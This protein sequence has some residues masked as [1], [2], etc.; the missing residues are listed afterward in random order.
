MGR[1]ETLAE[2]VGRMM[3]KGY[4]F[5]RH[6]LPHDARQTERTG[7]TLEQELIRAGLPSRSVVVVPKTSS[8]WIGINHAQEMFNVLS[9]RSPQCD[10]GVEA[11]GAYRQHIEAEGGVTRGEPIGDWA[12][13]PADAFRTMAEAHRAGLIEFRG[14][15]A[16]AQGPGWVFNGF[17]PKRRGM[18]PQRV[19]AGW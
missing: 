5:G 12:S 18:K 8:V 6:F 17:A 13:H 14:S 4:H 1:E 16:Q 15:N 7:L 3:A 10:A 19:S 11:L 2:R 9:F